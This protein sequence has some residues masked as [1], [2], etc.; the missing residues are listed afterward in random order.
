MSIQQFSVFY[1]GPPGEVFRRLIDPL[2]RLSARQY[3]FRWSVSRSWRNGPHYLLSL[4]TED[5][6]Y[7]PRLGL[8]FQSLAESFL[9]DCPSPEYDRDAFRVR[10]ARLKTIEGADVDPDVL[11]PNNTLKT[12]VLRVDEAATP[13]ESRRQ[14]ESVFDADVRFR[15]LLTELWC[16]SGR[17]E[18]PVA[19]LMLLL[20]CMLPPQPSTVA[21]VNEFNGFLSFNANYRFWLESLA[22]HQRDQI[23]ARFQGDFQSE[24]FGDGKW[25]DAVRGDLMSPASIVRRTAD[26]L[27]TLFLEFVGL[28]EQGVIHERSPYALASLRDPDAMPEFHRRL[29]FRSN[30][31]PFRF[32]ADFSGYRWL[33]NLVYRNLPLLDVAPLR[34]QFLNYSL[35][36][37]QRDRAEEVRA[38]REAILDPW[39]A[40]G[41]A[42]E[43]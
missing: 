14:W 11:E 33:L 21:G 22:E 8:A 27:L 2:G 32:Q 23:T 28:A 43:A 36:R 42:R 9:E 10:Q 4:D 25:L 37:V 29:F 34:R 26:L 30:G 41:L 7:S 3:F 31:E 17:T 5:S 15:P 13:Y 18:P 1:N 6:F 16:R 35:D 40:S 38:L 12:T 19:E 20:G 24:G 39:A